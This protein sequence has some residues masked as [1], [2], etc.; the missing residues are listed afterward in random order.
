MSKI[1]VKDFKC[2]YRSGK[3]IEWNDTNPVLGKGEVGLVT[4]AK[5]ENWLK[6]GDG[7][8]PWRDLE[9]KYGPKGNKGD[10][11]DTGKPFTY[12]D[13]TAE[14]IAALKGDKGEKGDIGPQ[15]IQGEKGDKGDKGDTG[16]QGLQGIQGERGEKGDAFTYDDFT[17]EQLSALK[18]DKG[19][20]GYTP[21]KGVDYFTPEDIAGLNIPKVDKNF[22]PTS[23]NAQSGLGLEEAI[24]IERKRADNTF[25]NAL[26]GSKSGGLLLIDDISPVNHDMTVKISSD[27]VTDLTAV[28]VTRCGK[29]LIQTN[30]I[31][32]TSPQAVEDLIW[33][34]S[35]S[36]KLAFSLDVSDY[37]PNES[38]VNSANFKFVF[39]DGTTIYL[40]AYGSHIY[41][42]NASPLKRIYFLNWGRGTGVLKN[43]QLEIGSIETDYEPYISPTYYTP[44]ADGTV[45]NVKSLYPHTTLMTDTEGVIISCE[46]NKDINKLNDWVLIA[47]GEITEEVFNIVIDKDMNGNGFELSEF[48]LRTKFLSSNGNNSNVCLRINKRACTGVPTCLMNSSFYANENTTH[49]ISFDGKEMSISE[50]SV[51]AGG[52]GTKKC[53]TNPFIGATFKDVTQ[54]ITV[55]S[56]QVSR[57]NSSNPHIAEGTYELWG[58]Y[59]K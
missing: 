35:I 41:L 18:G 51:T 13:F 48:H 40:A 47:K 54:P 55:N 36:G 38:N 53:W 42:N 10:K 16:V 43:I 34:G 32:V 21:Q 1:F 12:A 31:E 33:Q 3:A 29:N 52:I 11:G 44:N 15:G 22:T 45:E 5:D 4:D 28:K 6:I 14:Q 2:Q 23:E 46:Y 58:R 20:D 24:E 9:F 8:T 37:T 50:P 27:T 7:V 19:E 17:A 26:K 39:A 25:S 57:I 30:I 59:A 56:V 49:V